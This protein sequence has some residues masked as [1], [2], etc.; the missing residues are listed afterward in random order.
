MLGE[1]IGAGA[2]LLG[3]LF[4]GKKKTEN[5]VDYVKMAKNAQAAGF[6]PLTALRNGGSAGFTSS[7]SHPGLSGVADAVAQIGGTLGS[8][9]SRKVDPIAQKRDQVENALL[10]YQL[11]ALQSNEIGPLR[12]GDVP[13]AGGSNVVR[14]RVAPMGRKDAVAP[15]TKIVPGDKPTFSSVG[16]EDRLG[17]KPDPGTADAASFEQRYGEPGDWIGGAYVFGADAFHNAKRGLKRAYELYEKPEPLDQDGYLMNGA[18]WLDKA[19]GL[20]RPRK[21]GRVAPTSSW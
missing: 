6:N 16:L 20:E 9:I 12:F 2:S 18:K 3:S 8:A 4:G 5:T 19:L 17:W 10:D 13:T 14:Q 11:S 1:L 15:E 7:V 21:G